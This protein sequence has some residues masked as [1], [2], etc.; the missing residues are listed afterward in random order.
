[1]P[2]SRVFPEARTRMQTTHEQ[3]PKPGE[4]LEILPDIQWLRMPLPFALNHVNLWLLRDEGGWTAVDTGFAV[5]AVRAAWQ[6]LLPEYPLV[7]LLVTHFHPD[8][9]GLATHLQSLTGAPLWIPPQEYATAQFFYH[10]IAGF[11]VAAGVKA[12][13]QH[14]LPEANLLL[15]EQQGNSYKLGV[16]SI[17][18][19][20]RP[21]QTG[22]TIP[23]G[24]HPWRIITGHGHSPEHAS[25]YCHDLGVLIS[26]DMLLPR[27][28]T[29][30]GF[31]PTTPDID[32]LGRFLESLDRF[33]PLPENTLVLPSHGLPFRG[34]HE[35]IE[36]LRR[37]HA[38][39][40]G[41]LLAACRTAPQSAF[42]LLPILF[43]RD[44]TD[45]HQTYFAM[46]EAIAHLVYLEK[47]GELVRRAEGGVLRFA[48]S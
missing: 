2:G 36:Q 17:P 35:R 45:I 4:A 43:D 31:S 16:P 47:R 3:P 19:T 26:G 23:V 6:Q 21:L 5:D 41:V 27:I 1:M 14:G 9:L 44:I 20:Y 11:S 33:Q 25:L 13:R 22:Q 7:R 40:C 38:E 18:D 15:L 34:L 8:H 10:Q 37:H 39:R 32:P 30:I 46:G 28:S 48:A 42:E 12:F 24:E 29:N